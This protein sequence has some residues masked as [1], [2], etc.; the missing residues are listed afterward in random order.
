MLAVIGWLSIFSSS[1]EGI[2]DSMF[3]P[4]SRQMKQAV[5]VGL[6]FLMIILVFL[7]DSKFFSAFAYVLYG[8]VILSLVA[9]LVF[10][11]EV[12]GARSWFEL[13]NFRFQ[14]AE[15]AKI[16]TSLALAQLLT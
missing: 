9:V 15:F 16:F 7:I 11:K 8:L 1:W 3:E 2:G 6:S 13:G 12:N 10:G 14:P 4:G 5:W